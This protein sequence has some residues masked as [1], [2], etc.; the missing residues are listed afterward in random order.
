MEK[1]KDEV[2]QREERRTAN[3]EEKVAEIIRLQK[4]KVN[5]EQ[6]EKARQEQL[7]RQRV[8]KQHEV[9]MKMGSDWNR[10]ENFRKLDAQNHNKMPLVARPQRLRSPEGNNDI[11]T[12]Q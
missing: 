11:V 6:K 4:E 7:K 10:L 8:K 9:E 1:L 3:E 5:A 2:L 12:I